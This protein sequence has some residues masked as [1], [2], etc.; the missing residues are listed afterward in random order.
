MRPG[1]TPRVLP[2][3]G[4]EVARGPPS[5]RQAPRPFPVRV[6]QARAGASAPA[7]APA[8]ARLNAAAMP[9]ISS[10]TKLR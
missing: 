8:G 10:Q 9:K 6:A 7:G 3:S 5:R 4:R 2:V 1:L